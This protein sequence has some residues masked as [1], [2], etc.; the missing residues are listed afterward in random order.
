MQSNIPLTLLY[1]LKHLGIFAL[2][3]SIDGHNRHG[4]KTFAIY[5]T[6][7]LNVSRQ[8]LGER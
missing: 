1:S 8:V 7:S 3:S 5:C 2:H 4:F 6:Y